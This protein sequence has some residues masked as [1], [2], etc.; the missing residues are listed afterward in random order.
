MA[1]DDSEN[2]RISRRDYFAGCALKGLAGRTYTSTDPN[3]PEIVAGASIELANAL[4]KAL[5]KEEDEARDI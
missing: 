1:S 3:I 2:Y 5:A 4:I